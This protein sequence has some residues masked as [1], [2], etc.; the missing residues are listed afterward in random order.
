MSGGDRL[1]PFPSASL[2]QI[3]TE[4]VGAC[5]L[6]SASEFTEFAVGYDYELETCGNR[7]TFG[8]CSGCGHVQLDPRP[9]SATLATIYPPHY[10]SYNIDQQVSAVARKGKEILDRFKFRSILRHLG[11]APGSFLDVGCGDG[12]YLRFFESALGVPRDK[13]FGLELDPAVASR[14][15]QQGYRVSCERIES[16]T[17]IPRRSLDLVTMFHVIE[18]L[19]DPGAAVRAIA[20]LLADGGLLAVE[21]P[22][23]DALDAR[24]FRHSLWG[25]YHI[26]RHWH[27][28][29]AQS[30]KR[31]LES[32]GLNVV[33]LRY[34]TGHS[35]W[36]YSFH[37]LFRYRLG[38]PRIARLFDP[39]RGLPMLVMF[40]AFDKLRALFGMRTSAILAIAR[41]P[42]AAA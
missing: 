13:I 25:G 35:F 8:Q 40:T 27:L 28:F 37:H 2:P 7:W 15:Q 20:E 26:P 36:M 21:T 41:R 9:T 3:P 16:C 38:M 34:Q 10:Y 5:A 6:C 33:A 32:A 18:H 19:P 29:D 31:L 23:L 1:P 17:S 14:L 22:N 39:L 24:W 12:R 4:A 42:G 11:R 30:L